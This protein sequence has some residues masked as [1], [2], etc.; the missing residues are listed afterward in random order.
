M[1]PHR[2]R[3]RQLGTTLVELIIAVALFAIISGA[4][5]TMM[6][7]QQNAASSL[8]GVVGL[9]MALRSTAAMLQMDLANAGSGYYQNVSVSTGPVG[10]TVLNHFVAT[11]QSCYTSSTST[12]GPNCFDELSVIAVDSTYPIVNATDTTGGTDP[13][14]N[15]SNTDSGTAYGQLG[16]TINPSTGAQTALASL[17]ATASSYKIGDQLLLVSLTGVLNQPQQYTSVVL[18][19]VPTVNSTG[20]AVI[21]TFQPTTNG[22]NTLAND[23]LN[24]SACS[25]ASP[26]PPATVAAAGN[27]SQLTNSYCGNDYILKL[28]PI[29]Y[30]VCAGPG[31]PTTPYTCDQSSTSP[32]ITNPKLIRYAN[33][34]GSV[35]MEQVIGFKVG[36][37]VWNDPYSASIGDITNYNYDSSTYSLTYGTSGANAYDFTRLRSVRVSLIGRTTPAFTGNTN[38]VNNYVFR[39][40]FDHG[41]YQVQGTALV[42]NPR[43]MNPEV[44]Q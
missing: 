22:S 26:C 5:F 38:V 16:Y 44:L 20:K 40:G 11:G 10:V 27:P 13:N 24:I 32:D 7:S 35:V 25:G 4:A 30:Q 36:G 21:F 17:A 9:N 15:C 29:T 41:P 37:S 8:T 43:N 39:N 42:V 1:R 6:N 23:P 34:A 33:G 31:S 28:A 12:Y 3:R 19:A 2:G 14:N 18:T